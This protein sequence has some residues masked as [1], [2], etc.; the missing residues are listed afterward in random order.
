MR[1]DDKDFFFFFCVTIIF[2]FFTYVQTEE[3]AMVVF[4]KIT[5]CICI[6]FPMYR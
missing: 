2:I 1:D 4:L 5:K 6:H 3:I